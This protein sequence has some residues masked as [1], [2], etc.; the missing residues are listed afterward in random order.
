MAF[1]KGNILL[2][3]LYGYGLPGGVAYTNIVLKG[4]I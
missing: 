1:E 4:M 2:N 3:I